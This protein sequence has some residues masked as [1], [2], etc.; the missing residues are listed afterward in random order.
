MFKVMKLNEITK[1][2]ILYLNSQDKGMLMSVVKETRNN[3]AKDTE[4]EHLVK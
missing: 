2:V 3:Q 1:G 4:K